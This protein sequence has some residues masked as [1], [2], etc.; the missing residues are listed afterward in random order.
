ML[1]ARLWTLLAWAFTTVR[2]NCRRIQCIRRS[3]HYYDDDATTRGVIDFALAM[4]LLRPA[5]RC[6]VLLPLTARPACTQPSLTAGCAPCAVGACLP[7]PF[8]HHTI[9]ATWLGSATTCSRAGA[10]PVHHVHRGVCG[11]LPRAPPM[12]TGGGSTSTPCCCGVVVELDR[13]STCL[14]YTSDAA[15]E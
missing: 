15:D 12:M 2:F 8:N 7:L 1:L 6:Q 9:R 11:T 5:S 14:L 3:I 13:L 4:L 10:C